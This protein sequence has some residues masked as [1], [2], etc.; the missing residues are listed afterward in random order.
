MVMYDCGICNKGGHLIGEHK[1]GCRIGCNRCFK[2][3]NPTCKTG[4]IR[5]I[6]V[7]IVSKIRDVSFDVCNVS[8]NGVNLNRNNVCV[9]FCQSNCND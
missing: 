1:N 3:S 7:Y 2:R 6:L 5:T 9:K 4:D 8:L